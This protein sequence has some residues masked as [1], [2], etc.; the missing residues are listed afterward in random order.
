M[1]PKGM[2]PD[3]PVKDG[4]AKRHGVKYVA[5]NGARMDNLGEKR[6]KFKRMGSDEV[7]GITFQVTEVSKPLASVS[8]ILDKGNRVV[9]D[10]GP[11]G[12]YI[13]NTKTGEWFPLKEEKGTFIMEVDWLEP[14]AAKSGEAQKTG[15]TRP[16][17]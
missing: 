11:D 12:S 8:R 1:I 10:R 7:N 4:E 17:R 9:F 3:E 2:L 5:A 15:F 13:Q 6:A 16:G 14:E